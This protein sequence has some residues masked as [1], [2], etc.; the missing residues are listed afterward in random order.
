M[1]LNQCLDQ[2]G[3]DSNFRAVYGQLYRALEILDYAARNGHRVMTREDID[4]L[5]RIINGAVESL[6]KAR[7]VA[8]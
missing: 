2:M 8:S 5:H 1:T 7:D 3:P 4:G 6:M